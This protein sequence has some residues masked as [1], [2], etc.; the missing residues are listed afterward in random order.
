MLTGR[1]FSPK[2]ALQRY[3]DM[4]GSEIFSAIISSVI[5]AVISAVFDFRKHAVQ[6]LRGD[7]AGRDVVKSQDVVSGDKAG[8]DIIKR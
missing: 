8:R 6:I 4:T 7:T 1:G 3:D 5:G 2:I